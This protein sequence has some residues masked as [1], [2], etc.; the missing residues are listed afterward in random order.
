MRVSLDGTAVQYDNRDRAEKHRAPDVKETVHVEIAPGVKEPLRRTEETMAAVSRDFYMPAS[1]FACSADL[2]CIADVKYIICPACQTISP[3]EAA[4]TS[5]DDG[6]VMIPRQGVGLGFTFDT[7][8]KMQSS[9]VQE[10]K[11]MLP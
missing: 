9:L 10:G 2:F 3:A 5:A 6:G 4:A 7:L 11:A 1:C 8:F